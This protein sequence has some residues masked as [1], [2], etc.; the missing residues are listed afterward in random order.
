MPIPSFPCGLR[1]PGKS[2]KHFTVYTIESH[3]F[4]DVQSTTFYCYA[5]T[6]EISM[7]GG[8]VCFRVSREQLNYALHQAREN[9]YTIRRTVRSDDFNACRK[10]TWNG[11]E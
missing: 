5:F 10:H 9:G 1:F 11:A 4:S 6:G 3:M 2:R 7:V 8:A